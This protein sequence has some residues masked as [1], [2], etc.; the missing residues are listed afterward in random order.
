MAQKKGITLIRVLIIV[1]LIGIIGAIA[2]PNYLAS[3]RAT[4]GGEAIF[5]MREFHA[6][7]N[8]YLDRLDG[9]GQKNFAAVEELFAQHLI[10]ARLAAATS[11]YDEMVSSRDD[12]HQP[13]RMAYFGYFFKIK[14]SP[15]T[16][17]ERSRFEVYAEPEIRFGAGRTGDRTFYIDETGIIRAATMA[18][19]P[20]N[21]NSIPINI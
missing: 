2:L 14:I 6:A 16:A 17:R 19:P 13:R 15:A 10:D 4:N 5:A 8:I 12:N 9:A 11:N 21:V 18:E 3:K 20:A 7:E 1:I